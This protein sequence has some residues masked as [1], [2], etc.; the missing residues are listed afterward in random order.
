M[1]EKSI[2]LKRNLN[3]RLLEK[4]ISIPGF[5]MIDF[6]GDG[7]EVKPGRFSPIYVN[8]KATWNYPNVLFAVSEDLTKCC[9]GCDCI[10]G[11]ETGGSPYAS[12]IARELNIGLILARKKTKLQEGTLAGHIPGSRKDFA[13]VD[14]VL[15]TGKSTE[16]SISE[17]KKHSNQVRLV[18]VLSYGMDKVIAER[19]NVQVE[20]LYQ[21][22]DLLDC[23]DLNIRTK[24]TPFIRAFQEKIIKL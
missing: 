5:L 6:E 24:L 14:D 12:V 11:I 10:I 8:M 22:E 21:I 3:K 16:K 19:Y 2:N 7:I 1:H 15:A 18:S 13:I 9:L 17:I 23:L 20:S 4:M